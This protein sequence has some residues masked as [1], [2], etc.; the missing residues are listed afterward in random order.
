MNAPDDPQRPKPDAPLQVVI[1]VEDATQ[2]VPEY[3]FVDVSR[4][5]LQLIAGTLHQ[6][7]QALDPFPVISGLDES[8]RLERGMQFVQFRFAE[9]GF[10][11]EVGMAAALRFLAVMRT[12]RFKFRF[13]DLRV[14][15]E[16]ETLFWAP[17]SAM[18]AAA[19]T[20]KMQLPRIEDPSFDE[21][22]IIQASYQKHRLTDRF[23]ESAHL[24]IS[25]LF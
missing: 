11:P 15:H 9:A 18:L 19:A 16:G 3:A 21:E 10:P 7:Q 17:C 2:P 23:D 8:P 14:G 13:E 5:A 24:Y 12:A 22:E 4:L 20:L 25:H 1:T 6:S